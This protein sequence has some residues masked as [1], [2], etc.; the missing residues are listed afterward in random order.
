MNFNSIDSIDNLRRNVTELAIFQESVQKENSF[1]YQDKW[2]TTNTTN[3][4]PLCGF[5]RKNDER[6]EFYTSHRLKDA[7]GKVICPILRKHQCELCG[8]TGDQAHT[9]SYCPIA[10]IATLTCDTQTLAKSAIYNTV[11]LKRTKVNSA[12]K[13]RTFKTKQ[14][15]E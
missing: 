9:R 3:Q 2:Q 8:A 5:C 1:G 13:T 7:N 12:G 4:S 14:Q 6:K 11:T 10:R 15:N